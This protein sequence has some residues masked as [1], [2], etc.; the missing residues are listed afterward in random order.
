EM[1]ALGALDHPNIVEAHDAGEQS[2][3]VYLAMKL[4]DGVDLERLVK[5]RGPLP[6]AEACELI[7]QAAL[8]LHYLHQRG[9][10]HRDVKPSKLMR[11]PN[12]TVKVL[13]LGLARWCIEAE[14]GHGLTGAGRV[15]GT[16]DFLAPEQIENAADVDARGDVYGLGGTLY[17][18]LT[19]R[20]PFADRKS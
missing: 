13:D 15:M 11:T 18:L 4:I 19:G 16:P 10:A 12:G 3:V 9:L 5:Q 20:A 1:K 2:G 7:R 17:Y 14:G 8:G 6:I